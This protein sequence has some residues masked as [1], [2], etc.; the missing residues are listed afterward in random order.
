MFCNKQYYYSNDNVSLFFDLKD[1]K[2]LKD[3][4]LNVNIYTFDKKKIYSK[5]T[6]FLYKP[7]K[8]NIIEKYL[9]YDYTHI[10]ILQLPILKSNVY[11]F[12][13]NNNKFP[14]TILSKEQCDIVVVFPINTIQA[15]NNA[16]GKNLYYSFLPD[17]N[18]PA[19]K[20]TFLR[21]ILPEAQIFLFESC[22]IEWFQY[23]NY[24][25]KYITDHQLDDISTFNNAKLLIIIGH[26]EYL[27][28][29]SLYNIKTF[30]NNGKN[31]L[32]LSGNTA[33]WQVRYEDD[34]DTLVCYKKND[35]IDNKELI[36]TNFPNI[37]DT[38]SIFGLDFT[39]GGYGDKSEQN[40]NQYCNISNLS[41]N[42]KILTEVPFNY[43]KAINLNI[44]SINNNIRPGF[45]GIKI[46]ED[47]FIFK[48]IIKKNNILNISSAEMDGIKVKSFI[49]NNLIS[50]NS[51]FYKYKI[52]GFDILWRSGLT[53]G[54]FICC[55][56][57]ENSG[58]VINTG[59]TDWCSKNGIGGKDGDKI[60]HI[61]KNMIDLLLL[62]SKLISNK[63]F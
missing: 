52:L 13:I 54:G 53:I 57:L 19:T 34:N 24:N 9:Y 4:M 39:L 28:R 45:N 2:D 32:V 15:Y 60:K 25:M 50:D 41:I 27:T 1:L 35:P 48:D 61:T 3:L 21:P 30:I 37:M 49:D 44:K 31:M 10:G 23:Q 12:E 33:W 17:D 42:G 38:Y 40:Y 6:N 43:S 58:I 47:S 29:K 46:I 56:K 36:T 22:F 5:N 51:D 59:T 11:Y 62:E 16:G 20:V 63:L 55:Q 14:F 8:K 18:N 7:N 26:N